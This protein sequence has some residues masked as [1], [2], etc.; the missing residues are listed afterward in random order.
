MKKTLGELYGDHLR[1]VMSR[2]DRALI[3]GGYDGLIT[4]SG[5]Q[6]YYYLDDS[7]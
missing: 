6:V 1:E 5:R 2:A 7:T 4:G 3:A